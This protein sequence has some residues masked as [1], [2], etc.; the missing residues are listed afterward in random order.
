MEA[1]VR[2]Q[3][4]MGPMESRRVGGL[5]VWDGGLTRSTGSLVH[6]HLPLGWG[7]GAPYLEPHRDLDYLTLTNSLT[8]IQSRGI[9]GNQQ[10]S[11]SVL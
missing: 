6:C 8:V 9:V 3:G 5:R 7:D 4:E 10:R 1:Q 2:G 11:L